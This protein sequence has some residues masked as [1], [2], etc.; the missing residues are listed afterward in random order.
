MQG[1]ESRIYGKR[2]F[3]SGPMTGLPDY[4]VAE[5]AKAHARLKEAGAKYVY[6]P[7]LTY[8]CQRHDVAAAKEHQ[9]YMLDCI[10]EL[11]DRK[12]R[13]QGW[14]TLVPKAYDAL[15]RLPGWQDSDGARMEWEVAMA[16]GI[17]IID[18]EEALS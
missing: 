14:E 15:V 3:L 6:N 18:L 11:T 8:L 10:H 9:D 12:K 5:F 17:E 1:K 4:N 7:A 16:C 2:V 13:S